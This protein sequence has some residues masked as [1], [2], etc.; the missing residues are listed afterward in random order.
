MVKSGVKK[1]TNDILKYYRKYPKNN[2]GFSLI[3]LVVSIAILGLVLLPILNGFVVA[4][5]ANANSRKVQDQ[6]MIVQNIMEEM[7]GKT[8]KDIILDYNRLGDE[9]YEAYPSLSGSGYELYASNIYEQKDQYYLLKRNIDNRYDALITLDASPYKSSYHLRDTDY[10]NYQMPL[11]REINSSNHLVAVQSFETEMAKTVLYANY[12]S[13]CIGEEITPMDAEYIENSITRTINVDISLSASDILAT[14]DLVYSSSVT[15]CGSVSYTLA[16]R[17]MASSDEGIYVFYQ[18]FPSDSIR[19]TNDTGQSFDVFAYEQ[20]PIPNTVT[21]S[22]PSDVNFYSNV[23]GYDP[24]KK[25]EAQNRIFDITVQLFRT[26]GSFL[27]DDVY[28]PGELLV[29]LQ[30]TRGD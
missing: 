30:S 7:K 3:E 20:S 1:Q 12:V 9:C 6:N 14:V 11:V 24:V 16:T 18:G 21:V 15:G 29:Q 10:N 25:E 13:Y 26:N 8:V 19:I 5:R 23:Y 28:V 4:A 2:M 22:K 27:P 17:N